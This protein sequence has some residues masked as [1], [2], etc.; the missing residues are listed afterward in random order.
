MGVQSSLVGDQKGGFQPGTLHLP[1]GHLQGVG[2]GNGVVEGHNEQ[3]P[4]PL[5]VGGE[6]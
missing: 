1:L 4:R 6:L 5:F 3:G 2:H